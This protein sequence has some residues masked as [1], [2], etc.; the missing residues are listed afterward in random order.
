MYDLYI[1][2]R[3]H[4]RKLGV[5]H[6]RAVISRVRHRAKYGKRLFVYVA[7]VS[8]HRAL[9][10]ADHRLGILLDADQR[11]GNADVI[12]KITAGKMSAIFFFQ[13]ARR[14]F[15]HLRS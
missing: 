11:N 9:H 10:F 6:V 7:N 14:A 13:Y 1:V 15:Y 4:F 3:R 5:I 2:L 8:Y 12:V